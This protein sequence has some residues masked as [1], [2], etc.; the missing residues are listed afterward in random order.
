[1]NNDMKTYLLCALPCLVLGIACAR[2]D[3]NQNLNGSAKVTIEIRNTAVENCQQDSR[4][5][6]KEDVIACMEEANK[7]A[8]EMGDT[9]LSNII[10]S[11]IKRTQEAN[12]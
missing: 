11:E 4:F 8:I 7:I 5:Q 1:M 3:N 6:T 10:T 9:E 2:V 12:P